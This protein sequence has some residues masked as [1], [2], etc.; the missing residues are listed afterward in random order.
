MSEVTR[1]LSQI[2]QGDPQAAEKLLPLVYDGLRKL[3]AS[4]D[5]H[6]IPHRTIP[7]TNN[8]NSNGMPNANRTISTSCLRQQ[9]CYQMRI[10][11]CLRPLTG[12]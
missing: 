2:E 10:A 6:A 5:F 7:P 11:P 1:I 3:A 9:A 12:K 8:A 4:T